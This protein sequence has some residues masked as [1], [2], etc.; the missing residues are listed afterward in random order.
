MIGPAIV[1]FTMVSGMWGLMFWRM[2]VEACADK[3]PDTPRDR[4]YVNK[5]CTPP[6]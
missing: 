4:R 5:P 3:T 2:A 1:G 6:R